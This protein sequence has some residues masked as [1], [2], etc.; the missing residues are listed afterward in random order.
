VCAAAAPEKPH[1]HVADVVAVVVAVGCG[2][3]RVKEPLVPVSDVGE[4]LLQ[5][6]KLESVGTD[7]SGDIPIIPHDAAMNP[8]IDLLSS[9]NFRMCRVRLLHG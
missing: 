7:G 5:N 3:K 4:T 1:S 9:S 8:E 6:E 2:T